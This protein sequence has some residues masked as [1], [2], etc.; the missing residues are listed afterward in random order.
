MVVNLKLT[1]LYRND[2]VNGRSYARVTEAGEVIWYP[3]VTSVIRATSPMS[4]GLLQWYATHGMEGANKLRDEAAEY[5]TKLH[6][7]ISELIAGQTFDLSTLDERLAKDLLA[8]TAFMQERNIQALHSEA[9]VYSDELGFAGASDIVCMMEWNSK[10]VTAIVDIKSGSNSYPDHAVQLEM[11]RLAW[12]ECYGT[13]RGLE[14]THIFNWHPKDWQG[15]P[16][17]TLKN[18]TGVA[19]RDEID[20]RCK[21]YKATKT[22]KP[23]PSIKISGSL[24]DA[25]KIESVDADVGIIAKHV[26]YVGDDVQQELFTQST[27]LQEAL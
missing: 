13:E 12:N 15:A 11:Y 8:W 1:P 25:Y 18:Q 27:Q 7:M 17:Y 3:S 22:V 21:L 6:I 5:G 24:P 19:T 16:T 23:K 2:S 26:S 9:M 20:L 4:F 14:A 10:I